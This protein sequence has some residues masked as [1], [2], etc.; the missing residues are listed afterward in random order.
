MVR[1]WGLAT[2]LLGCTMFIGV[3]SFAKSG[4]S[5]LDLN[6]QQNRYL[7]GVQHSAQSSNYTLLAADL[8]L[9]HESKGLRAKFN[10]VGQGAF[11]YQ[12]EFYFGV[13]EIY[14][15]PKRLAPGFSMAVGRQKRHWSRLDEEFNLGIWQPQLRWDYL[16]PTQEGLTGL[17]FDL[18][19]SESWKVTFFT[20]PLNIP[21]Q[22]PQ[23]KLR[24]GQ[25]ES[26]NRWFVQPQ[27][28]L[29]LFNGTRFA[30]DVPLSLFAPA[31]VDE[32][33]VS[34]F[35]PTASYL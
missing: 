5:Y 10:P 25:F 9:E 23:F 18:K 4:A 29:Q 35:R 3:T 26:S 17:F 11:E 30:D 34:A 24:E 28:R 7:G 20:S 13:P 31:A 2:V 33:F 21:D 22:G 6:L 19:V 32:P 14:I 16:N 1:I 15:E 8:N 27:S 12:D